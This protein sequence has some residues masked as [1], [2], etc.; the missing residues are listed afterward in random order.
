M[1]IKLCSE[2]EACNSIQGAQLWAGLGSPPASGL[3]GG[4][5]HLQAGSCSPGQASAAAHPPCLPPGNPCSR[6]ELVRR[7]CTRCTTACAQPEVR[8]PAEA[9]CRC[10]Q[11]RWC[12]REPASVRLQVPQKPVWE[13][14]C[15]TAVSLHCLCSRQRVFFLQRGTP[16][17]PVH[18]R[19][20]LKRALSTFTGRQSQP[21]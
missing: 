1:S 14:R 4:S 10:Q 21:G 3:W 15:W 9:R 13:G 8:L 18:G 2:P 19:A 12:R 7:M 20:W 6:A 16:A 11:R 5:T 17:S